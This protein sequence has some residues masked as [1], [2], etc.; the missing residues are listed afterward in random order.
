MSS[1]KISI[2]AAS[3]VLPIVIFGIFIG[4][5]DFLKEDVSTSE[6]N[7]NIV[8]V[9]TETLWVTTN[10]ADVKDQVVY[11]LQGTV[12][13][14]DDPID[15]NHGGPVSLLSGTQQITGYIPVT[16]S[17]DNVFKGKLTD[18]EFTFYVPSHKYRGSYQITDTD[19]KFEIGENVLVHLAHTDL[20]PFPDGLY[21]VKLSQYGKYE[22]QSSSLSPSDIL[23]FNIHHPNGISL[24]SVSMEAIP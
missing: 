3:V 14:I 15:Y 2:I 6:A 18:N 10:I 1:K 20:G 16:I 13:S 19:P 17:I 21:F 11:T 12:L 7:P 4:T 8:V 23:A 22:L 24:N 9:Q 5:T